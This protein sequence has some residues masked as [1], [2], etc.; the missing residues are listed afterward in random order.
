MDS[1]FCSVP[2]SP[3]RSA[4]DHKSEMVSQL[5]F[6]ELVDLIETVGDQWARIRCRFDGYEGWCQQSHLVPNISGE[7]VLESM[8][9]TVKWAS[10]IEFD[11]RPMRIPMGSWLPG[12]KRGK[13]VWGRHHLVYTG[14]E[15]NALKAHPT[16]A[17][18]KELANRF[19]NSP[20]LWGGKTVFGSDCSGYTQTIYR[21]FNIRLLRD[22]WQQAEMG[23][24]IAT[25]GKA[26]I[27]D[28]AF[29]DNEAGKITHVG[30][31]LNKKE[32]IHASGKVRIDKIDEDGIVDLERNQ[33][34]HSL[35]LIR[36]FF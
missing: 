11:G 9:F 36:R 12:F 3:L 15:W 7:A 21:F 1:A 22:A 4:P 8:K 25:L 23:E 27:G 33:R 34:T 10:K 31:L 6:G 32:I 18:M 20:Y 2:V 13:A 28:L 19:L 24:E 17:K 29:F 35:K 5:Q 26:R 16:A 30:I 14:E